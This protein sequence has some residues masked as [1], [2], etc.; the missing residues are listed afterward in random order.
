MSKKKQET[1][2]T[3]EILAVQHLLD[4]GYD[5]LETNFRCYLGELDIVAREN[6]TLIFVEVRAK[7]GKK[8]GSA[9]ESITAEK[10]RRLKRL[11]SFYMRQQYHK[12]LSCRIDFI[13]LQLS[14]Y[15]YSLEQIDHIKGI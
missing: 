5:I 15:D 12:E 9:L 14:K 2:K 7:T 1:G 11:A 8:F 10:S 13:A 4:H 6:N 3:G